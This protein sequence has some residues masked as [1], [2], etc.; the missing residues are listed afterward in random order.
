MKFPLKI[1]CS[2]RD[3]GRIFPGELYGTK[4]AVFF[5]YGD[6]TQ[7]LKKHDNMLISGILGECSGSFY[8]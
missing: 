8:E 2:S 5:K 7:G 3:E 4:I 6:Q 1:S